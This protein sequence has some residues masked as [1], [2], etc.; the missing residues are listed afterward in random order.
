MTTTTISTE[1]T[2]GAEVLGRLEAAWN[3]GDGTAF[4]AEYLPDASFVTI[5]GERIVGG[6]AIGAGHAGI[7]STIYLGSVNTMVLLEA[8]RLADD[9]LL[10]VSRN[11]LD[12]P[13][14]PLAGV[15]DA[16]S[17]SVL[18]HVA[19]REQPWM[20]AATHNTFVVA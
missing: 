5:R 4:G 3:S 12:C 18:T 19:E 13:S 17:T 14:G 7:L 8:R 2:I 6:A 20:V 1:A 16:L 9:V 11:T 15:H 10:V